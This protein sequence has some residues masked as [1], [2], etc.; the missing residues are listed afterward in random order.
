MIL[1]SPSQQETMVKNAKFHAHPDGKGIL[2]RLA[3]PVD[4]MGIQVDRNDEPVYVWIGHLSAFKQFGQSEDAY[5]P[6]IL[7]FAGI[8]HWYGAC[9]G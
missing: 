7:N 1:P 6:A 9:C 2:V 4:L 5:R 8:P 3:S